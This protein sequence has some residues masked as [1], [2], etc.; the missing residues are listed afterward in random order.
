MRTRLAAPQPNNPPT[1]AT[2]KGALLHQLR[3]DRSAHEQPAES[4]RWP[5]IAGGVLIL[6]LIAAVV[7]LVRSKQSVVA[8]HTAMAR[9][10]TSG[11]PSASVL[12]ATGYVTARREATVSA[13]I[14]GTLTEVL[15]EEGDHVKV[16]QVLARL[17]ETS[18]RA[19][20]AQAEAQLHSAQALLVQFQK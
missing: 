12:D 4:R 17:E 19:A 5:W 2:D 16:G 14:T 15:I 9:P 20:L 3:I 18:Q 13:Q 6:V 10:M 1:A 7:G 11:G 8:V